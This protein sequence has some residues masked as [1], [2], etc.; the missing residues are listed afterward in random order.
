MSISNLRDTNL[1]LTA[2]KIPPLLVNELLLG[3]L[4]HLKVE[5][6]EKPSSVLLTELC[7]QVS[8]G[9]NTSKVRRGKIVFKV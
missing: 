8:V 6:F 5:K 1:L 2:I 4:S 9:I 7:N 3:F